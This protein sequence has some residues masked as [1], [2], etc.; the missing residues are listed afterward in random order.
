MRS[1]KTT[2]DPII[3][4]YSQILVERGFYKGK[5][6]TLKP[7]QSTGIAYTNRIILGFII[8]GNLEV[9]TALG[10]QNFDASEEFLLPANLYFQVSAG[11]RG[12]SIFFARQ[13]YINFNA[14]ER[15]ELVSWAST[16][17]KT[18]TAHHNT[19]S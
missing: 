5:L 2:I 11:L 9:Q 13:K 18:S 19:K 16:K 14:H 7:C 8:K 12:A 1:S 17:C 15:K 10:I 4:N 6:K 3:S